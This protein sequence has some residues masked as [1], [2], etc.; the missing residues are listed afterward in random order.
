MIKS[1]KIRIY[2]TKEQEKLIHQTIGNCRFVY[3]HFLH[4]TISDYENGIKYPGKFGFDLKSLKEE[5]E[6]L[7]ETSNYS[8]QQTL[9]HLD[10]A[11][12]NFF[13]RVKK[14]QTP[15]FPKFKSKKNLNQV[16]QLILEL[17]MI[18]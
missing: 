3:N 11:F 2:P 13:R 8:E 7:Y 16:I 9:L 1:H 4:K 6:W 10:S 5:N 17:L 15:G 18:M 14:K 12:K